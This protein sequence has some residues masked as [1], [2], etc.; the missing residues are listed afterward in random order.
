[1]DLE[2]V[3]LIVGAPASGKTTICRELANRMKCKCVSI[4]ELARKEGLTLTYDEAR[5]TWVLDVKQVRKR[6]S[7]LLTREKC[8][9]IE[10]IDPY[11]VPGPYILGI[12][13][14]C[15]PMELKKRL[16][17]RGYKEVKV[18]EN[19]EYEVIDGPLYDLLRVMNLDRIVEING[20]SKDLI[21]EIEYVLERIENGGRFKKRFDWTEE[22]MKML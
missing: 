2:G 17:S 13:V 21:K 22:F 3:I 5:D 20:C 15:P 7:E 9:I 16:K 19:L 10:T 14:R 11:S 12:A 1:M 6:V 18:R 4:S 8:L